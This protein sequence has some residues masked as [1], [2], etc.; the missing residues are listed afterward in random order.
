MLAPSSL[1]SSHVVAVLVVDVDAVK[2]LV[3][4]DI[5]EVGGMCIL[6]SEAVVPTVVEVAYVE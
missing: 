3:L 2:A 1:G 4:H 5:D 6:L